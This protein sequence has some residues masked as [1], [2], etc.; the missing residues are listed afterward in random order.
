M[1]IRIEGF[2]KVLNATEAGETNTN[3]SYVLIPRSYSAQD[4]FVA[5]RLEF[6]ARL[7]GPLGQEIKLRYEYAR[8]TEQRVYQL[9]AFCRSCNV[10]VGDAVCIEK[11]VINGAPPVFIIKATRKHSVLVLQRS[12]PREA[13]Q[14][15]DLFIIVRN[16]LGDSFLST[17]QPFSTPNGQRELT[18]VHVG[19]YRIRRD[20]PNTIRHY[21]VKLG[22]EELGACLA[23]KYVE[24]NRASN[25][26]SAI[27]PFSSYAMVQ[28][29]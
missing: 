24:I 26:I 7:N 10:H 5:D 23:S 19:D 4:F 18:F 28:E 20:A 21:D 16:D 17:P 27:E 3:D 11:Q 2:T 1:T 15:H 8:G 6:V 22:E 12:H 14:G 9:G 13:E 29:Q 25:S